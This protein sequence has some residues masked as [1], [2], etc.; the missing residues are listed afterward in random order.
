MKGTRTVAIST[1][2]AKHH[3]RQRERMKQ[4]LAERLVG[5]LPRGERISRV[6]KRKTRD[7]K[8]GCS[9]KVC[10]E[11]YSTQVIRSVAVPLT[12][13]H[14]ALKIRRLYRSDKQSLIHNQKEKSMSVKTIKI[15][16]VEYVRRDSIKPVT[17][18]VNFTG[19]ETIASRMIGKFV[20]VRSRNEGINA[21][22]VVLADSTGVELRDC[23]RIY[24]HR[25]KDK[26]IS[27][28]EGVAVSG[29]DKSSK[30]SGTVS[31]KVIL[32]DYSMTICSD[33][34]EKSIME[35]K[36]NAQG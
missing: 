35:M 16:E 33:K 14:M 12:G 13:G 27:W 15:D 31:A 10:T 17:E 34:A 5:E 8:Y 24:Y 21:G 19:E 1:P 7:I 4:E 23:R 30:I 32:E 18:I 2:I 6:L 11:R 22:T 28:Y 26:A 9:P 29:L 3:A 25:P 20:I 36:P